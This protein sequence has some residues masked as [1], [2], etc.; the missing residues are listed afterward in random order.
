[1][2]NI[3]PIIILIVLI[4]IWVLVDKK[5][6]RRQK[7][8]FEQMKN[9]PLIGSGKIVCHGYKNGFTSFTI[10]SKDSE[11]DKENSNEN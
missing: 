10:Y 5:E 3:I 6:K 1:M 11:A 4:I 2:Y 9:D 7:E 8:M